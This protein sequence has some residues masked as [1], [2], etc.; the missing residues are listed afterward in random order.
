MAFFFTRADNELQS[1]KEFKDKKIQLGP[2]GYATTKTVEEILKIYGITSKL[3]M[4]NGG[5]FYELRQW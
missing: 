2:K 5:G 1:V 3:V 4:A